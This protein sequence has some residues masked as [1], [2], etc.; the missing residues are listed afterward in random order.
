MGRGGPA[1]AV[2]VAPAKPP[3]RTA[4]VRERPVS[5]NNS[6]TDFQRRGFY[7]GAG[8]LPDGRGKKSARRAKVE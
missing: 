1:N 8:T 3:Y 6:H 4:T 2:K 5:R 7:L